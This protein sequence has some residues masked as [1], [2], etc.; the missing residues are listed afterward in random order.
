MAN[1]EDLQ[2]GAFLIRLKSIFAI[3]PLSLS[4]SLFLSPFLS[5]S[6]SLSLVSTMKIK[7]HNFAIVLNE[8]NFVKPGDDLTKTFWCKFTRDFCILGHFIANQHI[9]LTFIKWSSLKKCE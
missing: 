4:L 5:L 6:L 3:T 1:M 9:W 7:T 2:T 8:M